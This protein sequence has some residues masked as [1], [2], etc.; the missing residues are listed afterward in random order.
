LDTDAIDEMELISSAASILMRSN[1]SGDKH[2][3]S[4]Q[5]KPG[6]TTT[7]GPAHS[8]VL[9]CD[10]KFLGNRSK[11]RQFVSYVQGLNI[12]GVYPTTIGI[13]ATRIGSTETEKRGKREKEREKKREKQD[14]KVPRLKRSVEDESM[15]TTPLVVSDG[16]YGI[17]FLILDP[18]PTVEVRSHVYDLTCDSWCFIR[19]CKAGCYDCA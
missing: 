19:E 15:H 12:S 8:T 13:D 18:L 7:I 5:R 11:R 3:H 14:G 1:S 16:K 6:D 10:L 9:P 4:P 2:D 17:Q